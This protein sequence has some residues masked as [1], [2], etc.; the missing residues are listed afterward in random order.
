MIRGIPI[1]LQFEMPV[2]LLGVIAALMGSSLVLI[3]ALVIVLGV[4][5]I[6]VPF[7]IFGIKPRL[8]RL[9]AAVNELAQSQKAVSEDLRRI[10]QKL[11]T[12][13]AGEAGEPKKT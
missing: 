13:E 9:I 10:E 1:A 8:D 11:R 7:A 5:W 3:L 12:T 4:I 2:D 6:F